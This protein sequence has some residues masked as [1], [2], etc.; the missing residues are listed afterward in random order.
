MT[1]DKDSILKTYLVVL[2]VCLVASFLVATAAVKLA[3]RQKENQRLEKVKNILLV[4]GLYDENSDIDTVYNKTIE[5]QWIDLKTGAPFESNISKFE[6]LS[7]DALAK[8]PEYSKKILPDFDRANI[9]RRP[10]FMPVYFVKKD[11]KLQKIILPVYGKGLWST[12][13]GFLALD[14]DAKTIS[15][16]TFYQQGETPGLGGEITNPRWQKL[17]QGKQAFDAKGNVIINV[18]KGGVRPNSSEVGHLVDGLAGATLTS[19]GV[20]NLIHYWLGGDGFGPFLNRLK[21]ENNAD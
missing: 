12:L 18:V 6:K 5:K 17:W 3:S 11:Q 21:R 19:R 14:S 16:I 15:G 10:K 8:N 20:N 13:Y 1:K 7:F 9:K 2:G 4:A